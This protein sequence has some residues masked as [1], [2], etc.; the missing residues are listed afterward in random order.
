MKTS[1]EYHMLRDATW[2]TFL[3]SSLFRDPGLTECFHISLPWLY[4]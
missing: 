1:L 2:K 4:Y 3:K